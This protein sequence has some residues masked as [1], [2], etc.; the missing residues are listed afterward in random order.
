MAVEKNNPVVPSP[1]AAGRTSWDLPPIMVAEDVA[2]VCRID[3]SAARK[4]IAKGYYGPYYRDGR[5]NILT[6]EGFLRAI[7]G[8]E[9]RSPELPKPLE[10]PKV[11]DDVK[12]FLRGERAPVSAQPPDSDG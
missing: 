3:V 8:R 4:R 2:R 6:R 10:V 11:S 5:R 9:V 12:K 1:D 7:M